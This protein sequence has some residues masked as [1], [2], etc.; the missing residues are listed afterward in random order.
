MKSKAVHL[1]GVTP[2]PVADPIVSGIQEGKSR[3]VGWRPKGTGDL[4][5]ILTL[6]GAAY[7]R[8][9]T[10]GFEAGPGDFTIVRPGVPH[11]YGLE[12]RT[13][14]WKNIWVH[15]HPRPAWAEWLLWPA[16]APG[17]HQLSLS[18]DLAAAV[19]NDL[20][21]VEAVL[22]GRGRLK[23]ELAMNA[24]ERAILRCD[25][26]NPRNKAG[27][28]SDER[29]ENTVRWLNRN[30]QESPGIDE[31]ARR[32]GMSR[33][34]FYEL[35]I[36]QTGLTPVGYIE[37][38]RLGRARHLLAYSNMTVSEIGGQ[39]GYASPFYF[40]LRFKKREGRSPLDYRRRMQRPGKK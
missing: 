20:R 33:S 25:A 22:H 28:I 12:G 21:A 27:G 10:T 5:L 15:V 30:C 37:Q 2:S 24:L 16:L 6:G 8:S 31:L 34:R 36:Q 26:A 13:G 18:G 39:L 3:I 35:F 29:I 32:A 19:E 40:S 7:F 4:L 38:Q 11:D 17:I 1:P 23:K 9:G 14:Y